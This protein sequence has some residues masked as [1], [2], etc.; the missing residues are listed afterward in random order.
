MPQALRKRGRLRGLGNVMSSPS[1]VHGGAPATSTFQ[2]E[3]HSSFSRKKRYIFCPTFLV[4]Q[5]HIVKA[6]SFPDQDFSHQLTPHTFSPSKSNTSLDNCRFFSG[7]GQV[8]LQ[9]AAATE[10]KSCYGIEK[11]EWPARYAEVRLVCCALCFV[12]NQTMGAV[13]SKRVRTNLY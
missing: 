1:G 7:V 6:D 11:A 13:Y 9:V 10:C 8:V 5:P 3:S 12:S 2:H 4:K